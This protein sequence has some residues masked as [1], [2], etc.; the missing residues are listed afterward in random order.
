MDIQG[1]IVSIDHR[2]TLG[3]PTTTVITLHGL[4]PHLYINQWVSTSIP[5]R[6]IGFL[7]KVGGWIVRLGERLQRYGS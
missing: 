3:G 5:T 4:R 2:Q 6:K 1:E 7:H